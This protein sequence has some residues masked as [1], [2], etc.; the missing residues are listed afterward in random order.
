MPL[1]ET[2][3]ERST[4]LHW[5]CFSGSDTAIYFL[6][7]WGGVDINAQDNDGNSPLH[8]AVKSSEH[9]PNTRS[10]KELLIK[11]ANRSLKDKKGRKPIDMLKEIGNESL[12]QEI[13]QLLVSIT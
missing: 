10:L 4:P 9:F 11:G 8:L 2:D 1:N 3:I 5:A 6:L 7:A 12:K 13:S